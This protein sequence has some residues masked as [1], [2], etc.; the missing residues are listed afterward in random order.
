MKRFFLMSLVVVFLSATTTHAQVSI[1]S[2][3]ILEAIQQN[4][5]IE[6]TAYWLQQAV[7]M[8]LQIEHLV[9]M[10]ENTGKQVQNQV[11][12]LGNIG[13]IHSY[14]DF[15]DWYNRQLYLERKTEETFSNMNVTIG[16]KDY[17]LADVEG[18]A[19]GFD[20][21]FVKYWDKEFNEEQRKEMWANLGVTPSNYA[22][23]QTWQEREQKIAREFLAARA[24]H[25]EEYKRDM[26]R[27]NE[28][29]D[30]LEKDKYKSDDDPTKMGEKGVAVI[31]AETNIS[32]N[33]IL[34][35]INGNLVDIKEKMAVDM[36]QNRAPSGAPP[37]S[38]W[39]E[40][41]FKPLK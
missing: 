28:N 9:T 8:A 38:V 18:M 4:V 37:M 12:N 7:D 15:M 35:D 13:D 10:V 41:G 30:A 14:K 29:M 5:A 27:N 32:S 24:I 17:K 40:D 36:Y 31:N 16:K 1:V 6:Q 22:Y 19:Y 33:K 20:D 26:E 25:K 39:P 2:A 21:T 11:Q 23:I 34:N 3:P